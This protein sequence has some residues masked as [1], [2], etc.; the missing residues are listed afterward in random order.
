MN[1]IRTTARVTAV[2]S[3]LKPAGLRAVYLFG[4]R[5]LGPAR[6]PAHR[7]R[8]QPVHRWHTAPAL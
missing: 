1:E 7:T 3:F 2:S 4:L 8:Y 5:R 6:A